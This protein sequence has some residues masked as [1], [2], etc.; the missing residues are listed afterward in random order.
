MN[1]R[2]GGVAFRALHVSLIEDELQIVQLP[3]SAALPKIRMVREGLQQPV[4]A[5]RGASVSD[6]GL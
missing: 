1:F 5:R 2:W 3:G 4:L 6:L